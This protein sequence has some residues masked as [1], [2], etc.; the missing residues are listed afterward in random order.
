M[1]D[2]NND[3][4]PIPR[5]MDKMKQSIQALAALQKEHKALCT[6]LEKLVFL[7]ENSAQ[8]SEKTAFSVNDENIKQFYIRSAQIYEE[9]SRAIKNALPQQE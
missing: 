5:M 2:E 8:A 6:K 9:V 3:H 1:S 4:D 7:Y